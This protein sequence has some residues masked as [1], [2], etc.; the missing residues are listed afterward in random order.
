MG[1]PVRPRSSTMLT[2][3][4]TGLLWAMPLAGL[5]ARPPGGAAPE[6]TP[7]PPVPGDSAATEPS[8]AEL[9]TIR[10]IGKREEWI[11]PFAFRRLLDP[12]ANPFNRHWNEPPSVEDVSL[13]GGYVLLGINKGLQKAAE[14]VTRLPGWQHQVQPATARPPPLDEGQAERAA[15]LR[16]AQDY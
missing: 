14:A 10:V 13:D 11:D 5:S 15:R 16:A 8:V 6:A 2:A 3:L 4:A 7:V 12:D 1:G 9:D